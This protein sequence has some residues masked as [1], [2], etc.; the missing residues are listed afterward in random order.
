MNRVGEAEQIIRRITGVQQIRVRD[1]NNLSR[2]EVERNEMKL[3]L[4]KKIMSEITGRLKRLGFK[5]VTLDL[6]GYRTGSMLETL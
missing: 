1:Q 5:Y 3:F 4:D 2:I 6:E